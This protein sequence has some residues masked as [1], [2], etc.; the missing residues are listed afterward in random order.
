MQ[1]TRLRAAADADFEF[2]F[3]L[4]K[5]TLGPYVE[6]VWGW[7]DADQRAYLQRTID[8]DAT[9]VVVVD[10]VDVG[11]LNVG[12][13]AGD[14]YLGLIEIAPEQQNRGVG[15]PSPT[16]S[17]RWNWRPI[18]SCLTWSSWRRRVTG[19]ESSRPRPFR[20]T[21]S[22]TRTQN[23]TT[24]SYTLRPDTNHDWFSA[25]ETPLWTT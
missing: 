4:H 11:R 24:A 9:Q 5:Q 1:T 20:A 17:R 19:A 15:A 22:R 25:V 2:F 7:V 21:L 8:I 16:A 3:R 6:Q 18:S 13:L 12:H 10:G 14:V 23:T